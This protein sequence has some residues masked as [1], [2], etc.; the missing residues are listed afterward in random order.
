VNWRR[1]LP[2]AAV[3]GAIIGIVQRDY[4]LMALAILLLA[5]AFFWRPSHDDDEE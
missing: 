4:F 1:I 3:A 5:G 2:W